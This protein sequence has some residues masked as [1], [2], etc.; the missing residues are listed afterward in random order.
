LLFDNGPYIT[1]FGNGFGGADTSALQPGGYI[2][3]GYSAS[4]PAFHVADDF[5]VPADVAGWNIAQFKVLAYQTNAPAGTNTFTALHYRVWKGNPNSGGTVKIDCTGA[6]SIPLDDTN[7]AFSNVYRVNGSNLTDKT[8]AI[9]QV[10]GS[11]CAAGQLRLTP[12][13]YW[14]E[15]S[16]DGS[17]AYSGPWANPTVPW[18][19]SDNGQHY[20]VGAGTWAPLKDFNSST[21]EGTGNIQDVPFQVSGRVIPL[22][23]PPGTAHHEDFSPVAA[24]FPPT[25]S[26]SKAVPPDVRESVFAAAEGGQAPGDRGQIAPV[27]RGSTRDPSHPVNSDLSPGLAFDPLQGMSR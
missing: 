14:L 23:V 10:T 12:G 6:N 26:T 1:G 8:K 7:V 21:G 24:T 9:K 22:P 4:T 5:T 15:W 27:L 3:Y 13:T 20:D 2:T 16:L 17:G 18:D 11:I 19:P 25:S